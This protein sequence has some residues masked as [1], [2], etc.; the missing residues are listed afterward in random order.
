MSAPVSK[1]TGQELSGM[2]KE[3]RCQPAEYAQ[4]QGALADDYCNGCCDRWLRS[5]GS[6]Q[7]HASCVSAVAALLPYGYFVDYGGLAV[8]PALRII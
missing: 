5:P 1:V 4:K 6:F 3:R 7:Y 8:R 2:M